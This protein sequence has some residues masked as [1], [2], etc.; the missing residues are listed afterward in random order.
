MK[1]IFPLSTRN[2]FLSLLILT[3]ICDLIR[4]VTL[5]REWYLP[6][7]KFRFKL[8]KLIDELL[9]LLNDPLIDFQFT[10]D[11]QMIVL[12]D[13]FEIRPEKEYGLLDKKVSSAI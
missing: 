1:L 8:V 9:D 4:V 10:F 12:E 2:T 7:Q 13:Y 5:K 3:G 11:G 6:F